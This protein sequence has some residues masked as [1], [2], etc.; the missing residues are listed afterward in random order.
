[1]DPAAARTLSVPSGTRRKL[2]NLCGYRVWACGR[3]TPSWT[4]SCGYGFKEEQ[5]R[6]L[7]AVTMT[8]SSSSRSGALGT[9]LQDQ[10]HLQDC[11]IEPFHGEVAGRPRTSLA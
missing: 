9:A 5:Q 6:L 3:R 10:H 8:S 7:A 11:L 2:D 4:S 1:M